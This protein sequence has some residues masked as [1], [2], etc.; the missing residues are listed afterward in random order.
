MLR[1]TQNS[2]DECVGE[3]SVQR[4]FDQVAS[5]AKST[6]CLDQRHK[7]P[8]TDGSIQ[9]S[10]WDAGYKLLST[11][12]RLGLWNNISRNLAA[13]STITCHFQLQTDTKNK[14]YIFQFIL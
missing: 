8:P 2:K 9:H 5:D 7:N 4:E 14:K 6:S 3:V 12:V 11:R 10:Q 13:L 1:L